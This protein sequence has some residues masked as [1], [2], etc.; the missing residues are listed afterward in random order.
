MIGGIVLGDSL[1]PLNREANSL[2]APTRIR[3][4]IPITGSGEKKGEKL[5]DKAGDHMRGKIGKKNREE[6]NE[7]KRKYTR[8]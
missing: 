3:N 1:K 5:R 6:G 4:N 8:E 2:V 7:T